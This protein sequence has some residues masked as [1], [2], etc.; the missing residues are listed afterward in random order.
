MQAC[1]SGVAERRALMWNRDGHQDAVQRQGNGR[2]RV[3][4]RDDMKTPPSAYG[5]SLGRQVENVIWDK[6]HIIIF[7][8]RHLVTFMGNGFVCNRIQETDL[9]VEQAYEGNQDQS[10][11]ATKANTGDSMTLKSEGVTATKGAAGSFTPL[12]TIGLEVKVA[13]NWM[14]VWGTAPRRKE[15]ARQMKDIGTN[16]DPIIIPPH[17]AASLAI[18]TRNRP[19]PGTSSCGG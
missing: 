18:M 19:N 5:P 9:Y 3:N 7:L 6:P 4:G 13:A 8:F 17:R 11:T 2:Q 10:G 14:D 1:T 15:P 12:H 16:G